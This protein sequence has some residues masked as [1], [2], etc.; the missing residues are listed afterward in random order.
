MP[1]LYLILLVSLTG[2]TTTAYKD[3]LT[4]FSRTSYF[5]FTQIGK[6]SVTTDGN[7]RTLEI[8][9]ATSDQVQALE[10]VAKGVAEG[11]AKGIAP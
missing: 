1:I 2:C 9:N 5:T 10:K 8:E 11:M 3:E 7:K 4:E 6:V